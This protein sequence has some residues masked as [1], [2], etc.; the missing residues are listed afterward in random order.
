MGE[1][2]YSLVAHLHF[3][4]AAIGELTFPQVRVLQHE[5]KVP[6]APVRKF[7]T[8]AEAEEHRHRKQHRED[9]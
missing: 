9:A 7:H 5:G 2:F 4:Y 6:R 3:T 8:M 1:L